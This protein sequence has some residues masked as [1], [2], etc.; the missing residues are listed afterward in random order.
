MPV[1]VRDKDIYEWRV[2]PHPTK[3]D[4]EVIWSEIRGKN[5]P[6]YHVNGKWDIAKVFEK[7]IGVIPPP[8]VLPHPTKPDAKPVWLDLH[9]N[10]KKAFYFID[11]KLEDAKTT[12]PIPVPYTNGSF[13]SDIAEGRTAEE[14][15][16]LA[17]GSEVGFLESILAKDKVVEESKARKVDPLAELDPWFRAE[18]VR[19]AKDRNLDPPSRR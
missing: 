19:M 12:M 1:L 16:R 2:V 17:K 13:S 14:M 5:V 15:A 3:P 18:L 11:G 10:G 8:T 7:L 6:F 9:G 4:A